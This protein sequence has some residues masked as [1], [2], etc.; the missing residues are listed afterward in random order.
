MDKPEIICN[1]QDVAGKNGFCVP[2]KGG[3]TAYVTPEPGKKPIVMC[4]IKCGECDRLRS[5]SGTIG[6]VFT[7]ECGETLMTIKLDSKAAQ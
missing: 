2:N 6:D 4:H 1:G 5:Y 7:C 3:A